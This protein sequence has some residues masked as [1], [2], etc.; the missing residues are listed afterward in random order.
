MTPA[1][2]V[3]RLCCYCFRT[4]RTAAAADCVR[5]SPSRRRLPMRPT[6]APRCHA[7]RVEAAA[8]GGSTRSRS[9]RRRGL[10]PVDQRGAGSPARSSDV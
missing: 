1:E 7:R 8:C 4:L 3:T 9:G 5:R 6:L 10:V 2:A